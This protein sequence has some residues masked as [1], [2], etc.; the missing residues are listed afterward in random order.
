MLKMA[1]QLR[2]DLSRQRT[3]AL[4]RVLSMFI[5][6]VVER[7]KA[8]IFLRFLLAIIILAGLWSLVYQKV[9]AQN[10]S[11]YSC[12]QVYTGDTDPK[13][14]CDFCSGADPCPSNLCPGECGVPE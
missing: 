13:D 11:S 5:K 4:Y 9:N 2:S 12:G 6:K 7:N 3:E 1:K 10:F 14:Y 8:T